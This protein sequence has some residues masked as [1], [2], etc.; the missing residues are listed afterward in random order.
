MIPLRFKR[1][2]DEYGVTYRGR[3][4]GTVHEVGSWWA[5]R[6]PDGRAL[7]PFRTQRTAG[8]A[9]CTSLALSGFYGVAAA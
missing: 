3:F 9:L 1:L 7:S 8:R 4:V 5:A 2:G 6:T